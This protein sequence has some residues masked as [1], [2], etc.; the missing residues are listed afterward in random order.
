MKVELASVS[1][2]AFVFVGFCVVA[3]VGQTENAYPPNGLFEDSWMEVRMFGAKVG[4]AHTTLEREGKVVLSRTHVVMKI[5]RA[6]SE[7]KMEAKEESR[8]TLDGR[9][10]GFTSEVNLGGTPVRRAGVVK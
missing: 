5:K 1:R 2:W 9:M 10:L 7:V 8:E 3:A 6:S 4:Y